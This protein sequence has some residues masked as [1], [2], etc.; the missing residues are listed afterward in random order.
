MYARQQKR[1]RQYLNIVVQHGEFC[2]EQ[3]ADNVE[4]RKKRDIGIGELGRWIAT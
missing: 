1:S 2:G 3:D 4:F